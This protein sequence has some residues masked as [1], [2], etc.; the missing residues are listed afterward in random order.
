MDNGYIVRFVRK[1]NKPVE[2]FFYRTFE[3][4]TSHFH[5]FKDDDPDLYMRIEIVDVTTEKVVSIRD[6]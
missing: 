4:A 2:D 6:F 1:D 3:V 5:L